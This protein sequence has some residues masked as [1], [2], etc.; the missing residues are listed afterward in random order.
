VGAAV[1]DDRAISMARQRG[2]PA[3]PQKLEHLAPQANARLATALVRASLDDGLRR[4]V[5]S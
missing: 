2:W 3:E 1:L 5:A 4:Q